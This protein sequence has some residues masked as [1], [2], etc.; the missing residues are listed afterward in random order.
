M[1]INFNF[2]KNYNLDGRIKIF[3]NLFFISGIFIF[4]SALMRSD[5]AHIKYSS[6]IYTLVFIF[7]ILFFAFFFLEEKINKEEKETYKV[8]V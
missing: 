4:K 2:N 6:G 7:L 1:L 8:D 5:E 3:L